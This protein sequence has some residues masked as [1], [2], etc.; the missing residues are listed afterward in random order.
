MDP[1]DVLLWQAGVVLGL[2]VLLGVLKHRT[3][4][5]KLQSYTR[6]MSRRRAVA[7]REPDSGTSGDDA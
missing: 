3:R 4:K 7:R 2:M 5:T 6:R 1:R